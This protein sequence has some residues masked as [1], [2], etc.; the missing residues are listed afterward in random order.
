MTTRREWDLRYLAIARE[1]AS[2][3]KDTT[4][5]GAVIVGPNGEIASTGF[6]GFPRRVLEIPIRA[7]LDK[8]RWTVHAELNAILNAARLGVSCLG[9]TMYSLQT[10][11][12]DCAKA[13]VQAGIA[14]VVLPGGWHEYT[15]TDPNGLS[16]STAL[17]ILREGGVAVTENGDV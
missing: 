14:Q 7:E 13:I 11:C 10:P 2:W 16:V 15:W 4:K 6:N 5:I 9:L 3:S 17:T 8:Y 1:V 12:H